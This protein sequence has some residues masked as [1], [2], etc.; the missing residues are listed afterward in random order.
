MRYFFFRKIPSGK[1]IWAFESAS[2]FDYSLISFLKL[3]CYIDGGY[4]RRRWKISK[5]TRDFQKMAHRDFRS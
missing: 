4:E 2:F 5:R 1:F 3:V